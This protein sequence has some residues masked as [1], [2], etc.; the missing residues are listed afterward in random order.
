MNIK[1]IATGV[2]SI[3]IAA[4]TF[5]SS[6]TAD[7]SVILSTELE[8]MEGMEAKIMLFEVD[9]DWVTERHTHPGQLFVYVLEGSVEVAVE[10][11]EPKLVSAG[12]A[13][14]ERPDTPM[15]G[16]T[17]SS[18]GAKFIVFNVGRTGEPITVSQTE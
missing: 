6:S 7:D 14:Y 11:D 5:M 8:G 18:E 13:F 16:R 3:L 4:L 2:G 15:V 12:E 17:A 10:G 9:S 1:R